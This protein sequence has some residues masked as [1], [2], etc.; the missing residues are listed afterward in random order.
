MHRLFLSPPEPARAVAF[1]S[2]GGMNSHEIFFAS[3]SSGENTHSASC[4]Y[5]EAP[6]EYMEEMSEWESSSTRSNMGSNIDALKNASFSP[7]C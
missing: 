6:F 7:N 4:S 5:A 3:C 2:K 1:T